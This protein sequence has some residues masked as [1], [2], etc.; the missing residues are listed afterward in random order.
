MSPP[1]LV[2]KF[3]QVLS[4]KPGVVSS[5]FLWLSTIILYYLNVFSS[6]II[7]CHYVYFPL[8]LQ[9]EIFILPPFF[10][11]WMG[12]DKLELIHLSKFHFSILFVTCLCFLS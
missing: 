11:L 12:A 7:L 3:E 6:N 8:Q 1:E 9:D 10:W 5:F 4:A 2:K